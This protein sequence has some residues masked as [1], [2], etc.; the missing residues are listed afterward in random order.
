MRASGQI[1]QKTK[2]N[3]STGKVSPG[4]NTKERTTG[5]TGAACAEDQHT[6]DVEMWSQHQ[7]E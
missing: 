6:A 3:A 7:T 2:H 1:L 5:A 4:R